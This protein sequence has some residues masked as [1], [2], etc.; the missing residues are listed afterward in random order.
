MLEA[1][2]GK[3]G[4]VGSTAAWHLSGQDSFYP[5]NEFA[6]PR[7]GARRIFEIWFHAA[8]ALCSQK[9]SKRLLSRLHRRAMMALAPLTVQCMPERLRRLQTT[10]RHPA[11]T[12]PEATPKPWARNFAYVIRPRL[13]FR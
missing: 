11:S 5:A 3:R 6:R 8:S 10:L 1:V 9:A 13:L 4:H 7:T 12:T 2:A